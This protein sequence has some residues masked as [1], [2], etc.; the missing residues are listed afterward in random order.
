[1]Q[2]NLDALHASILLKADDCVNRA[3]EAHGCAADCGF[4]TLAHALRDFGV[5]F[6]KDYF[7][8]VVPPCTTCSR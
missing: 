4:R 8:F 2:D 5:M 7:H 1:M 6:V 3:T